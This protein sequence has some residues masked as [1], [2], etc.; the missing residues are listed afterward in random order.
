MI[1]IS[2]LVVYGVL[3]LGEAFVDLWKKQI[4]IWMLVLGAVPV[5]GLFLAG[6]GISWQMRLIGGG[7]GLGFWVV[8][9]VT[10]GAVGSADSVAIAQLGLA[11]GAMCLFECLA[12]SLGLLMFVA[13]LLYLF[14]I[15]GRKDT[16]PF[17]PFLFFGYLGMVIAM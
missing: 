15:V 17:F 6:T 1:Y 16:L 5:T 3:L 9:Y 12:I 2:C 14:R 8:G 10:K 11:F 7:I 4:P 13:I